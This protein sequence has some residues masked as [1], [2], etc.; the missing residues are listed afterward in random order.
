MN[1]W[2]QQ[3]AKVIAKAWADEDYKDR[4]LAD[5]AGVL[6]EEGIQVP[7]GTTFE[8]LEG[9]P[10]VQTLVLT[11]QPENL[12]E[13]QNIEERLAADSCCISCWGNYCC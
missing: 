3:W 9:R 12:G 10:G 7:P 2:R 8:V 5:P 13:I 6:R 11:A 1:D 4:L